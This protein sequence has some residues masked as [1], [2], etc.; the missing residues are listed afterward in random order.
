MPEEF[1]P[2]DVFLRPSPRDPVCAE[3]E[4]VEKP[5]LPRDCGETIRA[6]RRFRAALSDAVDAAVARLLPG[7]AREV[8]AR[9]LQLKPADIEAISASALERFAGEKTLT[10]RAHPADLEVLAAVPIAIVSD[11]MLRPGD[12]VFELRSGTIDLRMD[13]RLAAVLDACA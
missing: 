8:L 12:V 5:P 1:I 4:P 2:L 13:A 3:I 10:L 9:E 7:I 6:A 11:E